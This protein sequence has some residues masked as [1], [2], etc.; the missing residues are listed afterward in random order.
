MDWGGWLTAA[1]VYSWS[2]WEWEETRVGELGPVEEMNSHHMT[3]TVRTTSASAQT[4]TKVL[5]LTLLLQYMD[6]DH[7]LS[8]SYRGIT[9]Y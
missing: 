5:W 3:T 8:Y 1:H 9:I 6:D 4:G 7:T 2:C